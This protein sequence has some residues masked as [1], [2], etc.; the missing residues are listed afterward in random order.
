MNRKDKHAEGPLTTQ[1]PAYSK[2]SAKV[3]KSRVRRYDKR[4]QKAQAARELDKV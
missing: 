2:P 3:K 4:A 1:G